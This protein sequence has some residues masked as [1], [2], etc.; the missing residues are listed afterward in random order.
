MVWVDRVGAARAAEHRGD[1]AEA[2]TASMRQQWLEGC[3]FERQEFLQ[4]SFA[5]IAGRS[6][7]PGCNLSNRSCNF[8]PAAVP[9]SA[10]LIADR[11]DGDIAM[12]PMIDL[13][14]D[15]FDYLKTR[16][17]PFVDTPSTVLRRE[18]GLPDPSDDSGAAP[19]TASP[20]VRRAMSDGTRHRSQKKRPRTRAAAGTLLPEDKYILPLLRALDDAG[21]QGTFRE[22]ADAVGRSMHDELMPADF[23]NLDSG[24][25]RW[26][27]RLQFVRLRLVE[28]G[29][30]ERDTPRGIWAISEAGRKE[31]QESSRPR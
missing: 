11:P 16:A 17:E 21:G 10:M 22:I 20:A 27:S 30:L 25:V 1:R 4:A 28:R 5:S 7:C 18:L 14:P 3:R 8:V 29:L 23:E 9:W 12:C 6:S 15:I 24:G 26:Q 13:D 19:A 2:M 31:L